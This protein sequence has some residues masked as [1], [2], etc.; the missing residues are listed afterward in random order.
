VSNESKKLYILTTVPPRQ[1]QGGWNGMCTYLTEAIRTLYQNTEVIIYPEKAVSKWNML[2]HYTKKLIDGYGLVVTR[3][4]NYSKRIASYIESKITSI[5][6]EILSF[7]TQLVAQLNRKYNIT[8]LTDAF[9]ENLRMAF[10]NISLTEVNRLHSI[11]KMALDNSKKLIV[12]TEIVK[13]TAISVY[14]YKENDIL[15]LDPFIY[16]DYIPDITVNDIDKPKFKLLFISMD[17]KRRNGDFAVNLF[18]ALRPHFSKLELHISG[19]KPPKKVLSIPNIFYHDI[20]KNEASGQ[21]RLFNLYRT[22]DLLISPARYDLGSA[23]VFEAGLFG[24]PTIARTGGGINE[25]I[26]HNISGLLLPEDSTIQ[27]WK[28]VVENL[29]SNIVFLNCLRKGAKDH[30]KSFS[31]ILDKG[32]R[33]IEFIQL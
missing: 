25:N 17:W 7:G 28:C 32:Q 3:D 13:E 14:G 1:K 33:V 12:L 9:A 19:Q 29:Y 11:D 30:T 2:C 18:N 15:K 4:V 27:D 22:S 23:A 21:Q 31:D 26:L 20:D 24:V 6:V 8:T 5:N 16:L 10:N